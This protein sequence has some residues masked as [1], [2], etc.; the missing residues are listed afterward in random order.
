MS[1]TRLEAATRSCPACPAFE[2]FHQLTV[3]VVMMLV[4]VV[5]KVKVMSW[6]VGSR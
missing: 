5:M 1:Q 6:E 3:L 2:S 4:N